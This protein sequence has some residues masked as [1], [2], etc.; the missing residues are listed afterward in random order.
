MAVDASVWACSVPFVDTFN[1]KDLLSEFI[2]L[3]VGIAAFGH[4][5]ETIVTVFQVLIPILLIFK[6][7][8]F[9]LCLGPLVYWS[10][11]KGMELMVG[12]PK[13]GKKYS[14]RA[15]RQCVHH[16]WREYIRQRRRAR[17]PRRYPRVGPLRRRGIYG[18]RE[19]APTVLE[20]NVMAMLRDL[21]FEL[22]GTTR[23]GGVDPSARSGTRPHRRRR[24]R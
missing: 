4:A 10:L 17:N 11:Y 20:R 22:L 21:R 13:K 3:C 7:D 14:R 12:P 8:L 15:R 18:M 6:R 9:F 24:A 2:W 1:S 5:F 16:S 19:H 23:T